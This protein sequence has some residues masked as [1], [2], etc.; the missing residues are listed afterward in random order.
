MSL[1]VFRFRKRVVNRVL[2]SID[3]NMTRKIILFYSTQ[4]YIVLAIKT[5]FNIIEYVRRYLISTTKWIRILNG[6]HIV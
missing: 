6:F 2:D 4:L 3:N 1:V 5:Y